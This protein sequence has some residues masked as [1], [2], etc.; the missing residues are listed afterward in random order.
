LDDLDER[1]V[2]MRGGAEGGLR[3][4]YD[5]RKPYYERY[6]DLTVNVDGLT[7]AQAARAIASQCAQ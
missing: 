6:A 3:A 4:L 2:V 5:E 1:G 7:I